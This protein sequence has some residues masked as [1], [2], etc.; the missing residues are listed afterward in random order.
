MLKLLFEPTIMVRKIIL[1]VFLG[2]FLSGPAIGASTPG[3]VIDRIVAVVNQDI[4]TLSELET[5]GKR[6]FEQ[7]QESTLPSEREGKIKK[8]REEVLGQLIENKLLEQEIKNKKIEV[9]DHE[10]DL[11]IEDIMNRNHIK[12]ND[13]KKLLA[14]DGVTLSTYRETIRLD[15][16]RMRL[17]NKE[18]RSKIVIQDEAIWKK[19]QEKQAQFTDPVEVKVQQIFLTIPPGATEEEIRTLQKEGQKILERAQK[20]ED[21]GTLARN[22]SQGPEARDD[23]VLGYFKARELKPELEEIAFRLKPGELSEVIRTPDGFHILRLLERK[24]GEAK[25]F[26]E[27]KKTILD[28]MSQE[29]TERQFQVWLKN[30]KNKAH[31]EM[32]L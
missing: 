17:I 7:V 19:Y 14:K 9:S 6:F 22:Y 21:F 12:E 4:I 25:P 26:S 28:E 20:G 16:G 11:A 23:G 2:L 3:E 1:Y 18:I 27:M 10:V 13:L 30:L 5:S 32:R 29:E 24:G 15:I 8:A 31:I